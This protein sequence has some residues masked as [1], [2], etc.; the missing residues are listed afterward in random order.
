MSATRFIMALV[1]W[2]I[3]TVTLGATFAPTPAVEPATPVSYAK[4]NVIRVLPPITTPLTPVS[5]VDDFEEVPVDPK[6]TIEINARDAE[7]IAQT[8][9]GEYR[10]EDLLQQAGVVWCVL[11][12][13]DAWGAS[14]KE[15]VTAPNQFHGY[16]PSN[17]VLPELYDMAADVMYRWQLEKLGEHN[18][19]RVLPSDYLWFG[20]NESYTKNIF[21]NKFT[22]GAKWDWSMPNPYEGS[23]V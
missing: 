6:P 5:H 16:H 13:C 17:P 22:G 9:Y 1:V 19:G 18:V 21:R 20:A 12:R 4:P 11:N 3:I 23:D 2:M 7:L 15:V 14:I 10:G 8:L